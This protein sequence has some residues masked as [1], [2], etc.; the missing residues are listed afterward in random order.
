M[1]KIDKLFSLEITPEQFLNS[2]SIEELHEVDLLIGAAI[3]RETT[4]YRIRKAELYRERNA[5]KEQVDILE[6]T[7]DGFLTDDQ[8]CRMYSAYCDEQ[9]SSLDQ[10]VKHTFTG[11][12]LKEF[13][14]YFIQ[15]HKRH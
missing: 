11:S 10:I 5:E 8:F 4:A 14:E 9:L 6:I 2:C 7:T 12:E 15:Q 1:P 3:R 13:I